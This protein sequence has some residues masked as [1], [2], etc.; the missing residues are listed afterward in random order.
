MVVVK[1]DRGAERCGAQ[2]RVDAD[3]EGAQIPGPRFPA[4]IQGS[5]PQQPPHRQGKM[6]DPQCPAV[7]AHPLDGVS[8]VVAEQVFQGDERVALRA[9]QPGEEHR[10]LPPP[11]SRSTA[12]EAT[13][14][15]CSY[16]RT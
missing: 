2:S 15:G 12:T 3:S 7:P 6:A 9:A 11:K 1:G 13:P 14:E 8:L 10:G 4:D 5:P 16:S